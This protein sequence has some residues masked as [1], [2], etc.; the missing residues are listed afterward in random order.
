MASSP[1]PHGNPLQVRTPAPMQSPDHVVTG[2]VVAHPASALRG[3]PGQKPRYGRCGTTGHAGPERRNGTCGVHHH[4]HPMVRGLGTAV[5]QKAMLH[6]RN[7]YPV[8]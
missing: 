2:S 1:R 6:L 5:F 4:G 7:A 8:W 3:K